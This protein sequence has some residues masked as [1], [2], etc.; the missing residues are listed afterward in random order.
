MKIN[1]PLSISLCRSF[2]A[3]VLYFIPGCL[4]VNIRI[5]ILTVTGIEAAAG[6]FDFSSEQPE[7]NKAKRSNPKIPV[8]KN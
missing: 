2:T 6:F 3:P 5:T 4:Q 7:E 8:E 1:F